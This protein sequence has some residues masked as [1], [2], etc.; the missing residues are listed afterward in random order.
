MASGRVSTLDANTSADWSN[1]ARYVLI[2][3]E[4][5]DADDE[6]RGGVIELHPRIGELRNILASNA[7]EHP[8][9]LRFNTAVHVRR[10][11]RNAGHSQSRWQNNINTSGE[12]H[13]MFCKRTELPTPHVVESNRQGRLKSPSVKGCLPQSTTRDHRRDRLDNHMGVN[14]GP[15]DLGKPAAQCPKAPAE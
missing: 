15:L 2:A 14:E 3:T 1:L 12:R 5:E 6:A 4:G 9:I 13:N 7:A 11:S 8:D 10:R